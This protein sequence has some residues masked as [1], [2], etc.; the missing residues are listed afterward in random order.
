MHL[1]CTPHVWGSIAVVHGTPQSQQHNLVSKCSGVRPVINWCHHMMC[2]R[3]LEQ[4]NFASCVRSTLVLLAY[5]SAAGRARSS[6]AV[7]KVD[8]LPDWLRTAVQ[9]DSLHRWAA[10]TVFTVHATYRYLEAE[11]AVNSNMQCQWRMINQLYTIFLPGWS[12]PTMPATIQP[13]PG[14][15]TRCPVPKTQTRH[16][17]HMHAL[18]W[19][20]TVPIIY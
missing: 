19:T 17:V 18:L 7:C 5:L 20:L 2:R 15:L 3:K 6:T 11:I 9:A 16:T 12:V 8:V 14:L 10:Q 1:W 13:H 4:I